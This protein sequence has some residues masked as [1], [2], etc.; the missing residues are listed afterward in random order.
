MLAKIKV[1]ALPV[2]YFLALSYALVR[3]GVSNPHGF[4]IQV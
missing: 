1:S 4:P 3:V 2:V